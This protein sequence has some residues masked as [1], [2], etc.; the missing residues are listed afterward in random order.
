MAAEDDKADDDEDDGEDVVLSLFLFSSAIRLLF[1]LLKVDDDDDTVA[2]AED[3]DDP[4]DSV[5]TGWV[6]VSCALLRLARWASFTADVFTLDT[7]RSARGNGRRK[8]ENAI[9]EDKLLVFAIILAGQW[10][11]VWVW[12]VK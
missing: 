9:W 1:M 5:V 11:V 10:I 4:G 8:K 7:P 3:D 2:V 12:S 6:V